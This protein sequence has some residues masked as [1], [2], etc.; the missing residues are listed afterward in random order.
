[1]QDKLLETVT[2]T[3]SEEPKEEPKEETTEEPKEETP[4]EETEEETQEEEKS[5]NTDAEEEEKTDETKE[6]TQEENTENEDSDEEKINNKIKR[7]HINMNNYITREI[8]NAIENGTNKFNLP[9]STRAVQVTGSNGVHDHVIE[10]EIKGIFEPLFAD[11]IIAKLGTTYYSEMPMEDVRVPVM[12]AGNADWATELGTATTN[13][14]TFTSVLL[15]PKR[16]SAVLPYS[17]NIIL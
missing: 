8:R 6:E 4:N 15:Q 2:E 10:T 13:N 14:P 1:M 9:I 5:D 3:K 7:N 11:S 17:K 16:I 12:S